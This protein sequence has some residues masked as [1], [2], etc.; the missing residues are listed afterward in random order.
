[1]IPNRSFFKRLSWGI[2]LLLLLLYGALHALSILSEHLSTYL[3]M[4]FLLAFL[5]LFPHLAHAAPMEK[6][7]PS[8]LSDSQKISGKESFMIKKKNRFLQKKKQYVNPLGVLISFVAWYEIMPIWSQLVSDYLSTYIYMVLVVIVFVGVM[9]SDS[10]HT[11]IRYIVLLLPLLLFSFLNLIANDWGADFKLWAYGTLLDCLPLL[12]G[13]YLCHVKKKLL[14]FESKMVLAAVSLTALTTFVGLIR[15]PS[16]ARLLATED[17]EMTSLHR[18]LN[19]NNIGGYDFIYLLVLLYPVLIY[20][21]KHKKVKLFPTILLSGVMFFSVLQSEYT[22]ALLFFVVSTVLFFVKRKFG[23][24]DLLILIIVSVLAVVIFW[25]LVSRLILWGSQFIESEVMKERLVALAGGKEGLDSIDD[26]RVDLYLRSVQAFLQQ[27]F[28]GRLTPGSAYLVAGGHSFFLDSLAEFGIVGGILLFF[29]YRN[30]YNLFYRPLEG[31]EDYGFIYW[32]FLL[33]TILS[34]LNTGMW[35]LY[36][37]Y[38]G[39]LL[40]RLIR[41]EEAEPEP[42]KAA[43]PAGPNEAPVQAKEPS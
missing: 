23:R 32:C 3:F 9:L 12:F 4:A 26:R 22:L 24:K 20:A 42:A 35:G 43:T 27:P 13:I 11:M 31:D 19:L 39:P 10:F 14:P 6:T 38:V 34:L 37:M 25:T 2:L 1:M 40:I 41:G 5:V 7:L 15:Y 21:Y 30:A 33:P 16:A 17:V 29:I 36:L 28:L 18:T 8:D